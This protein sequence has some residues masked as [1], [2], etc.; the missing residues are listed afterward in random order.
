MWILLLEMD[1]GSWPYM[2]FGIATILTVPLYLLIL[3]AILWKSKMT[4]LY[5]LTVSQ[6]VADIVFLLLYNFFTIFRVFGL[7]N[8]FYWENRDVLL[9]ASFLIMYYMLYLRCFGITLISTQRYI[10]VRLCGTMIEMIMMETPLF[11]FVMLHWFIPLLITAPLTKSFGGITYESRETME[12]I[13]PQS[14]LACSEQKSFIFLRQNYPTIISRKKRHEIRLSIQF[15]GLMIAFLFVFVYSVGQYV[16]NHT[17]Q[18]L[19]QIALLY[20]WRQLNPLMNCFLSCI[21][22]WMCLF[23]N[24]D[25]RGKLLR[26]LGYRRKANQFCHASHFAHFKEMRK[27]N[28]KEHFVRSIMQ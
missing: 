11:A 25:I 18:S 28:G 2:I 22:P 13:V 5:V 15:A 6:A 16:F 21:Q 9:N 1:L 10:T 8:D 7:G 3:L 26:I 17:R 24:N 19:V 20:E 23:F 14:S 4:P 27:E 12:V